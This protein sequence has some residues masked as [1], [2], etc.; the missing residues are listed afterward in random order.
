MEA[1]V[2]AVM[3]AGGDGDALASAS[4]VEVRALVPFDGSPLAAH[5]LDALR[6]SRCV[7]G[8]VC[9]GRP[10][11]PLLRT[12]EVCVPAGRR[13]VDSLALGLGAALAGAPRRVLVLTAD[14]PWLVGE[15]LDGLLTD[16]PEADLVYPVV[17]R[18][19]M[20]ARF[21]GMRRT[22]VRLPD[23][24]LTGGNALV[25]APAI[26]PR[27]LLLADRAYR[28]RKNPLA[29]AALVGWDVALRLIARRLDIATAERRIAALL[30]GTARALVTPRAA[31]AADV[32]RA[33]HLPAAPSGR[34]AFEGDG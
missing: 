5:T 3:L 28:G 30:G 15:D 13:L 34:H 31:L 33:E 1:T 25:I 10:V 29:L 14:L 20:E 22:Y 32:D 19:A 26:V 2:T 12:G 24:E 16:A 21:P 27:M 18:E 11:A 7:G 9:V 8:I 4:G 17:P 6:T 23:G